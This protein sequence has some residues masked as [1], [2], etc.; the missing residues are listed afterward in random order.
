MSHHEL[1]LEMS[2]MFWFSLVTTDGEVEGTSSLNPVWYLS[3][4]WLYCSSQPH[5]ERWESKVEWNSPPPSFWALLKPHEKSSWWGSGQE[6]LQNSG[7]CRGRGCRCSGKIYL[8]KLA[9]FP[10]VLVTVGA[11]PLTTQLMQPTLGSSTYRCPTASNFNK[12]CHYSQGWDRRVLQTISPLGPP[13]SKASS[14]V[15][16]KGVRNSFKGAWG[17]INCRASGF[18]S[19]LG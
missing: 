2:L 18:L 4:I 19:Q 3:R 16:L 8:P 17:H 6:I 12:G 14:E 11:S 13:N 10:F 1:L 5:R 7:W 15:S 9:F